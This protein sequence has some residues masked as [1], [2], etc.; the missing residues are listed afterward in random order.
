LSFSISCNSFVFA[1]VKIYLLHRITE[2]EKKVAEAKE[3]MVTRRISEITKVVL[4]N[5][6]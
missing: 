6:A 4:R 2:F 1:I 3:L 5:A